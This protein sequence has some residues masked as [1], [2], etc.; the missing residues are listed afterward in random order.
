MFCIQGCYSYLY[1]NCSGS[2]TLFGEEREL[3]CLLSFACNHVVSVWRGFNTPVPL[4]AFDGLPS[5]IVALP[6][7]S[8]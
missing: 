3:I 7:P 4:G 8:I 1:V 2:I 5:F 6:G